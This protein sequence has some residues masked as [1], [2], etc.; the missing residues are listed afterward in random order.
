MKTWRDL[1]PC[2]ELVAAL[3]RTGPRPPASSTDQNA[4]KNWSKAFADSCALM[5][6]DGLRLL[7]PFKSKLVHPNADGTKGEFVTTVGIGGGKGKRVDV[8]VSTPTAGLEL[9]MS[10][11]GGNFA[12]PGDGAFGK[13]LTG[14]L[15][16][17]L[18]ETREVH[19]YHPHTSIIGVYFFP[20]GAA[21]DRSTHSTLAKAVAK[22]RSHTGRTDPLS[23]GQFRRFDWSA[24]ALYTHEPLCGIE[25]GVL[26]FFDTFENP[27]RTGRPKVA[28]TLGL[29][30]FLRRVTDIHRGEDN[31]IDYAEPEDD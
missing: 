8:S 23:P 13:N 3:A 17:L 12:D 9:A 24:V 10:L 27:P 1:E 18:D 22:L 7:K 6:A 4:K 5:L 11:K 26:R 29:T 25:A 30:N 16:E 2:S 21:T 28:T 19:E 31:Q 20:L 14:R 15:Y